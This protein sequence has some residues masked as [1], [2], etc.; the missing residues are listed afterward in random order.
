MDIDE[1]LAGVDSCHTEKLAAFRGTAMLCPVSGSLLA[2]KNLN[3]S[4]AHLSTCRTW[5]KDFT[6]LISI[7]NQWDLSS[8]ILCTNVCVCMRVLDHILPLCKW[9]C[10]CV[11]V[12]D[13]SLPLPRGVCVRVCVHRVTFFLCVCVCMWSY[14]EHRVIFFLK[15]ALTLVLNKAAMI[16]ELDLSQMDRA[17]SVPHNLKNRKSFSTSVCWVY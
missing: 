12:Q 2:F 5:W 17:F 15:V 8:G 4:K 9:D 6:I 11:C 14:S 13:H 1:L 7:N 3:T 10:V 16:C